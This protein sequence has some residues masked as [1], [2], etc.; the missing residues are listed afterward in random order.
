VR[1][2]ISPSKD[3]VISIVIHRWH[4]NVMTPLNEGE[5]LNSD[6]DEA[7]FIRGYVGSYP[8][9]FFDVTLEELPAFLKMLKEY[10]GSSKEQVAALLRFG[11]NRAENKFWPT[12]DWF[13]QDFDKR[14]AL[15]AGLFDLNR[16]YHL[17]AQAPAQ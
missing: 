7:D 10:D 11:V 8:N 16:Y 12:Y 13:Q 15:R 1:I 9:Y 4:D 5:R 2:R 6:K 3:Q 17:A 14:D